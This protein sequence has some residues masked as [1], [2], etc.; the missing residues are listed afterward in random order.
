MF[1]RWDRRRSCQRTECATI[2]NMVETCVRLLECNDERI[3]ENFAMAGQRYFNKLEEMT[4]FTSL[5][6]KAGSQ[7]T[8]RILGRSGGL[9][10]TAER[11]RRCLLTADIGLCEQQLAGS[12]AMMG[13]EVGARVWCTRKVLPNAESSRYNPIPK[14]GI[15][16]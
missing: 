15:Q 7:H 14:C 2:L 8:L 4:V 12:V 5:R 11:K 3:F 6:R 10:S 13:S 1:T 9:C 16:T